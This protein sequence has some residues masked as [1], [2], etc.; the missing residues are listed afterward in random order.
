MRGLVNSMRSM[1]NVVAGVSVIKAR[2][3]K[4]FV[5]VIL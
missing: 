4:I 1:C 5:Y 2:L 3:I